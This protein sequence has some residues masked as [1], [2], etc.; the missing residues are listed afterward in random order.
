MSYTARNLTHRQLEYSTVNEWVD[1]RTIDHEGSW[2]D[3]LIVP[4]IAES[5]GMQFRPM[6]L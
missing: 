2:E 6:T 5:L 3:S 1:M 4:S